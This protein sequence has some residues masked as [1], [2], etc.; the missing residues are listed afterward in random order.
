MFERLLEADCMAGMQDG[1]LTECAWHLATLREP[2][3]YEGGCI[4]KEGIVN[5]MSTAR[6]NVQML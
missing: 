6:R 4:L 5:E 1:P 2:I 3:V